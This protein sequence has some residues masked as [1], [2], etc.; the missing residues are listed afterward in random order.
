[1][2]NK[3]QRAAQRRQEQRIKRDQHARVAVKSRTVKRKTNWAL[4]TVIGILVVVVAAVGIFAYLSN[5]QVAD[6]QAG[7]DTAVN[8]LASIKTDVFTRVGTG[9]AQST[10]N[11]VSDTTSL[12]GKNEKPI[13]LYIGGEY[14]PYCAA[15]RWAVITALSRF[16]TFSK[17]TTLTSGEGFVPTFTFHG[18]S[19]K[20]DYLELQAVESADNTPPPN[21][22]QLEPLTADQQALIT[23]YDQKPYVNGDTGGIPF[24]DIGNKYVSQ[25]PFYDPGLLVGHSYAEITDQLGDPASPM[26]QA[27]IG[28]ANYL[29]AVICDTLQHKPADICSASFVPEILKSIPSVSAASTGNGTP[30][31]T[32]TQQPVAFVSRRQG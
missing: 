16:G 18:S 8:A 26:S 7:N 20:S 12:K 15:H 5:K 28:S 31:G 11:K 19:Y 13:F 1:M 29:T 4:W 25:G 14:C 27:I 23:K 21:M 32:V 9:N 3:A 6:V 24:V 22:K 30:T 2:G 17:V 10:L